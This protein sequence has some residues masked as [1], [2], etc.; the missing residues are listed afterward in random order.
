MNPRLL[1]PSPRTVPRLIIGAFVLGLLVLAAGKQLPVHLLI[2][3]SLVRTGMNGILVLAM[4][5]SIQA[6]LGLN[7]GLPVGIICG[8]IGVLI[9][10]EANVSG[11]AGLALSVAAAVPLALLAGSVYGR[12]LNRV[13]GQEMMVGTYLGFAVVSGMCVFWLIAPFT[14][15]ILIWVIGGT[16]LRYTTSL[17]HLFGG[18]LDNAWAFSLW[19]VKVPTGLLL[20]FL[21][22]CLLVHCHSRTR[23]GMAMHAAGQN[24]AFATAS[25]VNT[26]K[27]RIQGATL[28]TLLGAIGII[29]YAQSFGFLQLYLAPLMMAFPAVAA[30]LIGGASTRQV[31]VGNVIIGTLLFQTLLTI[32]LPVAQA[33][34]GSD[35][36]EVIRLIVANGTILYAL[37]RLDGG[38]Q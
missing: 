5:P 28:S 22:A 17:R 7:F 29:I 9:A 14:N 8:L 16:G 36:T 30:V 6:G 2:S 38:G 3:D 27:A 37:T 24:P 10:V 33:V 12:L 20:T 4:V 31:T 35:V 21:L 34:I 11:L 18:V 25:G 32:S 13:K 26:A 19:G 23:G 1:K 15:P